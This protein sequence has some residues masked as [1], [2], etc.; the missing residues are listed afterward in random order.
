MKIVSN[1]SPLIFLSK[2]GRLEI[3]SALFDK[4]YISMAVYHEFTV[5][6]NDDANQIIHDKI[7]SGLIE[8]FKVQNE[9][10]V[11]T[12]MGRLHFGEIETIIGAGELKVQR[13]ILDDLYARNKA[14]Q[15][16]LLVT[17]TLG[18]L[19]LGYHEGIIKDI[20]AEIQK[21]KIAGFR[22][23]DDIIEKILSLSKK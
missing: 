5:N 10:A 18:I 4:V 19:L 1:T 22:I 11:K 3:L 16:D 14:R 15:F 7:T 6:K 23:S 21:L 12:L 8:V 9:V 13:V 2:I 20:Q 17:G